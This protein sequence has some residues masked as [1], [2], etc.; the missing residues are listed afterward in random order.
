MEGELSMKNKFLGLIVAVS[1]FVTPAPVL[2]E[3]TKNIVPCEDTYTFDLAP[4]KCFALDS[5]II[6]GKT[7]EEFYAGYVTFVLP[8]DIDNDERISLELDP[9]KGESNIFGLLGCGQQDLISAD[10][11]YNSVP[12]TG[13]T[14]TTCKVSPNEKTIVDVTD[15]VLKNLSD[16]RNISFCLMCNDSILEFSSSESSECGITMNIEY[17]VRKK[18]GDFVEVSEET[19]NLGLLKDTPELEVS[20]SITIWDNNDVRGLKEE[21]LGKA[22]PELPKLSEHVNIDDYSATYYKPWLANRHITSPGDILADRKGGE[23]GQR[24]TCGAISPSNPNRLMIGTD[25]VG[26]WRS[27]DFGATWHPSSKGINIMG[28]ASIAFDPDNENIVYVSTCR[29]GTTAHENAGIYKSI[30][31]GETW[32]FKTS[33]QSLFGLSTELIEFTEKN[34]DGIRTI[35]AASYNNDGIVVSYDGGET[36]EN[37]GMKDRVINSITYNEGELIITSPDRG[38]EVSKDGGKTWENRNEGFLKFDIKTSADP[39]VRSTKINQVYRVLGKIYDTT[40]LAIDPLDS[41]H[42]VI[43]GYNTVYESFN[44]GQSWE[45]LTDTKKIYGQSGVKAVKVSFSPVFPDGHSRLW[46]LAASINWPYRYS[47][48][49]GKTF[50]KIAQYTLG[51]AHEDAYGHAKPMLFDPKDPNRVIC[52]LSPVYKSVDGGTSVY[53]VGGGMSGSRLQSLWVNPDGSGD[54]MYGFTDVGLDYSLPSGRGELFPVSTSYASDDRFWIRCQYSGSKS[55]NGITADPRDRNRVFIMIGNWTTASIKVSTD[56]GLNFK[57]VDGVGPVTN[58]FIQFHKDNNDIIYTESVTSF[59]NGV[60]WVRNEV[61]IMEVSPIN[62]D[63]VYGYINKDGIYRSSDCGRTWEKFAGTV[64]SAQEITADYEIPDRLYVGSAKGGMAIV[65]KDKVTYKGAE[66]GLTPNAAGRLSFYCIVQNPKNPKHLVTCGAGGLVEAIGSGIHESFDRGETWRR[67]DGMVGPSDSKLLIWHPE[68]EMVFLVTSTG[69]MVYFPNKVYDMNE[70]VYLDVKTKDD[71]YA[72]DEIEYL[73][74]EGISD[75]YH[76]GYFKPKENMTRW[77][78]VR[79]MANILDIETYSTKAAFNDVGP[80]SRHY[81]Y[82]QAAYEV[83]LLALNS[84]N[85]FNPY[86]YITYQEAATIMVRMLKYK[87]A[88]KPDQ[89]ENISIENAYENA[90]E[91]LKELKVIDEKIVHEKEKAAT[92]EDLAHMIYN[93]VKGF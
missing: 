17:G 85:L 63:I 34:A 35:Y 41:N 21:K 9:I 14:I 44:R 58:S 93:L 80:F 83:G 11:T 54:E 28:V 30:D 64:N 26:L 60:T 92:R 68:G 62:N 57:E 5:E 47:D 89:F 10:I 38:I 16:R 12:A 42:W 19:L 20:G 23:M 2:A 7:E 45:I 81:P 65:E 75:Q 61:P 50:N 13:S 43:S 49:G 48:D 37:I 3:Q 32:E 73:F 71:S 6:V 52:V 25:V 24:I 51:A 31:G 55:I 29:N 53:P 33:L 78:F 77:E 69:T 4:D 70:Y 74:K 56:R 40:Q 59:D 84:E 76:D 46:V 90:Y 36:W 8:S 18:D 72:M 86:D 91:I 27:D 82:V 79:Y 15:Y 67:V 87:N 66:D 88:I 39:F 1:M 22:L